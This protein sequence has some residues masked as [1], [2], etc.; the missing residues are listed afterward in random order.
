MRN[1]GS[2]ANIIGNDA[3]A[4]EAQKNLEEV[5]GFTL[6][7]SQKEFTLTLQETLPSD[8][9]MNLGL[10]QTVQPLRPFD[11]N[12]PMASTDVGDVSWTVPTIGFGAATFIPGVAA[13]TWQATASAGMSVGQAGMVIA[14]KTLALTAADLL[15]EPQLVLAA[16]ADL[17]KKLAGKTYESPIPAGQK[18]ILGYRGE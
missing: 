2:D 5:G 1:I 7:A 15:T 10:T 9:A 16:K 8:T 6:N 11:P 18:P 14:A 17:A 3:L 12:A 4:I 13:H